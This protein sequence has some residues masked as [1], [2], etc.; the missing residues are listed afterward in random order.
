VKLKAEKYDG[1]S[2]ANQSVG[3]LTGGLFLIC[4][5]YLLNYSYNVTIALIESK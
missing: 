2:V 1:L 3:F 4:A 5:T